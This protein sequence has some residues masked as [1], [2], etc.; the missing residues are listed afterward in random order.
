MTKN[1]IQ[2]LAKSTILG[3]VVLSISFMFFIYSFDYQT[4]G[5][6]I[7]IVQAICLELF[8]KWFFEKYQKS[9]E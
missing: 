1:K 8:M 7:A 2:A 5:F 9:K 6:Y 3:I 4:I